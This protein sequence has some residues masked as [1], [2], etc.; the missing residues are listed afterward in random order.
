MATTREQIQWRWRRV[1]RLRMTKT[2]A[3][4]TGPGAWRI[5]WGR[6]RWG[7]GVGGDGKAGIID[8]SAGLRVRRRDRYIARWRRTHIG[9]AERDELHIV[10]GAAIIGRRRAERR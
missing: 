3:A 6:H 7:Q 9:T 4:S 1:R 2:S 8:R 10:D 5:S